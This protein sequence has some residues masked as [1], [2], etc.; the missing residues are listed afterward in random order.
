MATAPLVCLTVGSSDSSGGAGIQGDIKTCMALGAYCATA[1][2]GITAQNPGGV[3]SRAD[4][5]LDMISDQISTVMDELRIDV[6]KIGTVWSAE[7]MHLLADHFESLDVPVVFDPVMKT[8]A[9]S[10]MHTGDKA[11]RAARQRLMAI[12]TV[13]TPN[14][15]EAQILAD[16]PDI[17]MP[18]T[19]AQL[20]FSRGAKAVL[21]TDAMGARGGDWLYDGEHHQ[22]IAARQ[23]YTTRCEHGAGCAHSTILA[24]LLARRH[25][26]LS[27]AQEAHRLAAAAVRHGTVSVGSQDHP[28]DVAAG[29]TQLVAGSQHG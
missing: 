18:F 24:V 3:R 7:V 13:V 5:P 8:S 10:P 2:V 21:I 12:S 23:R 22:P 14:V 17:H 25:D 11:L 9:G 29:L 28:V 4:V 26:L 15:T 16:A 6:I 20:V 1:I 19:L 27:A